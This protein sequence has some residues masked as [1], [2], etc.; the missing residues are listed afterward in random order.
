MGSPNVAL[1]TCFWRPWWYHVWPIAEQ[2]PEA[3][4]REAAG[5][6]QG[7]PWVAGL[8]SVPALLARPVLLLSTC[9]EWGRELDS[10]RGIHLAPGPAMGLG[11]GAA[12]P[13]LVGGRKRCF[14]QMS[15]SGFIFSVLIKQL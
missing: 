2:G 12:F 4:A 8:Q 1:L 3:G 6:G 14:A 15:S 13:P 11:L 9:G 7:S 5:H 10:P